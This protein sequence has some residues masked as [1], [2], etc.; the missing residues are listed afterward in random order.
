MF[1]V[2]RVFR[3]LRVLRVWFFISERPNGDFA[4]PGSPCVWTALT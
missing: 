4:A 2:F 1:R 3:V